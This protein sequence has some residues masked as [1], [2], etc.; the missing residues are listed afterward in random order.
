MADKPILEKTFDSDIDIDKRLRSG[1]VLARIFLE[2]QGNDRDAA[3]R[4]LD[5]TIF[6][7]L[8]KEKDVDLIYVKLYDI[9]KDKDREFFSGVAEIK[10]ITRDFRSLATVSMKYGPSAVEIIE[11]DKVTLKMDE[12]LSLLADIS[13]ISQSFSSHITALLKDDERR[14]FYQKIIQGSSKRI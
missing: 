7:S 3:E 9:L 1:A 2:V 11:P 13:E 10:L 4:A 6:D 8:S 14:A 12:M 5:R